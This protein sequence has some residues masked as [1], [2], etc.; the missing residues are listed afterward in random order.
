MVTRPVAEGALA[1]AAVEIIAELE[2]FEPDLRRKLI[3][4]VQRAA[5]DAEKEFRKGGTKGGKSFADAAEKAA[6]KSTFSALTQSI[7]R[8]QATAVRAGDAQADAAGKVRIAEQQLQETRDRGNVKV[9]QILAAEERLAAARRR[10]GQADDAAAAAAAALAGARARLAAAGEQAGRAAGDGIGDGIRNGARRGAEDGGDEAGNIF[11]RAFSRA[12]ERAL[13]AGLLRGFAVAAAGLVTAVSPISTVLGG[14]AASAVALAAAL[15]QASGAAISLGGVLGALALAGG[16]VAAGSQGVSDALKAQT[17]AL[18]ELRTE[19]KVSAATQE[20]LNDALKLL[21]PNAAAAVKQIGAL[22]PA[23]QAVRRVVQ[24]NLFTNAQQNIAALGRTFL[25]LLRSELGSA[26]QKLAETGTALTKFV[27]SGRGSA[28]IARIM[29]SLN[30]SL[31]ILLP[32]VTTLAPAFLNIFEA[33]LPFAEQLSTVLASLATSFAGFL[34]EAVSSGDFATFMEGAMTAAGNLFQLLGNIGSIIGTVFSAGAASGGDLLSLLRDLTGSLANFLKSAQGQE[35]L[36]NFFGLIADSAH[37]LEDVFNTLSPLLGG[38]GALFQALQGP[39]KELGAALAPVIAALAGTLGQTLNQLAPI[40]AQLLTALTPVVAILGQA[41]VDAL[42]QLLPV[43]LQII[44]AF[45]DFA[46]TLAPIAALLATALLDTLAQLLP[47]FVQLIPIVLQFVQAFAAG[48]MPV[49]FAILPVLPQLAA[50]LVQ[51]LTAFIALLPAL[52]PLIPPLA[53]LSLAFAQLI[54]AVLPIIVAFAQVAA[55]TLTI[56]APA[57][58]TIIGFIIP[59]IESFTGLID[60]LTRVVSAVSG[61]VASVLERFAALRSGGVGQV[62]AM[63][64]A[65]IGTI[66]P[67]VSQVVGFFSSLVSRAQAVL[68]GWIGQARSVAGQVASGIISAIRTGLVG[69]AAVF[70]GPFNQ[71]RS[72]VA[73]ALESIIGVVSGAVDRISGLVSKITGALSRIPIP[74]GGGINIPFFAQGG[75]VDRPTLLGAGEDGPEVIIP[76]TKPRRRDELLERY[77]GGGA[78]GGTAVATRPARTTTVNVPINAGTVV[79]HATLARMVGEEFDK[80]FGPSIGI[81]T[82]GGSL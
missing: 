38:I 71:A 26:A 77:F 64:L 72:A 53:E 18:E 6:S 58:S 12:A 19:G 32:I 56:L 65:I 73:G 21:S 14:A 8:L 28:Q 36:T 80:R 75:L 52:L 67:F 48:L 41:L 57:L 78:G 69:L 39:I 1:Q 24:D 27:T 23:W 50:A 63:V 10:A 74:G 79:D 46:P 30:R 33:S 34:N 54:I 40:L 4:A 45:A 49:L 22:T 44:Q 31:G 66:A 60:M 76:L 3:D 17:K 7:E 2:Q 25:P 43:V 82:S 15:G 5:N 9:S 11:S 55:T 62:Q 37:V 68:S 47:V 42:G 16:A 13:G 29:D 61:F 51:I 59:V 35:L 20:K 70:V 81:Y